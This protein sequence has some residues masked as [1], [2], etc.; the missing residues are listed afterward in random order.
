MNDI[1]IVS[2]SAF[3]LVI[4]IAC[5]DSEKSSLTLF[6]DQ[7]PTD[8]PLLFGPGII[9]IDST[10]EAS[11]TFNPDMSKLFFNRRNPGES[12]N[13]HTMKL[14]NGK[15]SR[16]ALASFSTNKAYLDFHPRFS[17]KGDRLYFGSTRP[18]NDAIKPSG[19]H[20]WYV[21]KTENGWGPPIPLVEKPFL[22]RF[23]MCTTPS[24]AGNLYFTSKETGEKLEDEGIYYAINQEGEYATIEKM[25]REINYPGKWIAH[26]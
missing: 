3:L 19:L 22:D 16:P 21:E 5:Q 2:I 11:I 26:P 1:K 24:E 8:T 18:L 9:S 23:I 6:S 17:P 13:I 14:I 4:F 12:H 15:W 7:I 20:Q 25:S 10:V